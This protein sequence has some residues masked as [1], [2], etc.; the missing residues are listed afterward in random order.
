MTYPAWSHSAE[1]VLQHHGVDPAKGLSTKEAEKRLKEH[2]LNELK[3]PDPTS[4]LSL[5]LEQFDDTLVKILL[6]AAFVSFGLAFFEGEDLGIGAFVEPGVIL[7]ILILNAIVGV[8]QE[9][10]AENALE[11]LKQMSAE[12]SK[13]IR[14]GVMVCICMQGCHVFK[15]DYI[16]VA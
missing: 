6:M 7:L 1:E 8:W 13:V 9:A 5:V 14:D 2:G 10:N 11:A 16:M 3:K 4:M 15:E 12:T